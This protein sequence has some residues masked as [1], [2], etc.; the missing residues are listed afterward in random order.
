VGPQTVIVAGVSIGA[1]CVIGANSLV[2]RD[3]PDHSIAMGTP[4]RIRG[5]VEVD[6]E[7]VNLV[8]DSDE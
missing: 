5:R 4:A 1:H 7:R 6:G 3:V 2:N 8:Y